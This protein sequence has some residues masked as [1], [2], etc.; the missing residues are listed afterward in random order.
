MKADCSIMSAKLHI[1]PVSHF[2][3]AEFIVCTFSW[4][5]SDNGF[6]AIVNVCKKAATV[7]C[8]FGRLIIVHNINCFVTLC[9]EY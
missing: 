4:L 1:Q 2:T 7:C 6:C 5:I 8:V 9:V 3:M